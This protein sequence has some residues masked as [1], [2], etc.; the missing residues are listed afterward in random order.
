MIISL[1]KHTLIQLNIVVILTF[2]VSKLL[3]LMPQ[4]SSCKRPL[5]ASSINMH[6]RN[7]EEMQSFQN[8]V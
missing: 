3:R 4:D 8:D 7:P 1:L 6:P 5:N 2:L